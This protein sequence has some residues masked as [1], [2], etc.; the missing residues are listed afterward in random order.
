MVLPLASAW[1][2]IR[3]THKP[4]MVSV[5]LTSRD[6]GGELAGTGSG[7][8]GPSLFLRWSLQAGVL[9][10][11]SW[12][13]GSLRLWVGAGLAAG[14]P[15]VL[16]CRQWSILCGSLCLPRVCP[17]GVVT[18]QR[19]IRGEIPFGVRDSCIRGAGSRRAL[20]LTFPEWSL[21]FSLIF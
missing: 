15:S 21:E 1:R 14:T 18:T 20:S 19:V 12:A 7:G 8:T 17:G 4:E 10:S 3:S 5:R 9:F 6:G 13:F 2:A 11:G 16:S